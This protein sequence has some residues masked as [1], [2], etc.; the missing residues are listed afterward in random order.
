MVGRPQELEVFLASICI[1]GTIVLMGFQRKHVRCFQITSPVHART[2]AMVLLSP[3]HARTYA[4]VSLMMSV[5]L[6]RCPGVAP[7][8]ACSPQGVSTARPLPYR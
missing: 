5:V 6:L 1:G 8:G 4:V 3:V 7:H 2:Q